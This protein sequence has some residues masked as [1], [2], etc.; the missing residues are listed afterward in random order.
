MRSFRRAISASSAAR[1]LVCDPDPQGRTNLVGELEKL[2]W[3]CQGAS[4]GRQAI[5]LMSQIAFD[6][7]FADIATPEVDG[8]Q[9]CR[10]IK[11]SRRMARTRVVVTTSVVDS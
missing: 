7:V 11:R 2:G 10:A 5:E 4:T 6:L 3:H 9:L 1:T 8:L